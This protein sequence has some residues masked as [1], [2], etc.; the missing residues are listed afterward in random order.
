MRGLNLINLLTTLI[1][2][3]SVNEIKAE[4]A[5]TG[6]LLPNAGD[7]QSSYQNTQDSHTPDKVGS[8]SGFTIDSGIQAFQNELEAKGTGNVTA[9]GSLVGITTEKENGGQF[10]ITAD[11]LDGGVSLNSLTEVQNCEWL[12][13]TSRCGSATAGADSYK[14]ILKILDDNNNVLATTSITRNN[15]A[16]YGV[17]SYTYS[18]TIAHNGTGARKW[19]WQWQG[20]DG[21][22]T[23]ATASV[24]PNLLGASL[25]ATL[26]DI[27]FQ[28]LTEEQSTNIS[29]ANTQ[30][31]ESQTA[32]TEVFKDVK[33]FKP[34]VNIEIAPRIER[35]E[36][37]IEEFKAPAIEMKKL[38][39]MVIE[40]FKQIIVKENLVQEFNTALVEEN[41][42]EE[43][44]F[45]EV[46]NMM[47]EELNVVPEPK[48]KEPKMEENNVVAK[49]S[50][51]EEETI[52][53][54][55]K[56]KGEP[57]VENEPKKEES[58][59]SNSTEPKP[60]TTKENETSS[61][62]KPEESENTEEKSNESSMDEDTETEGEETKKT[63]EEKLDADETGTTKKADVDSG[64][65]KSIASSISAKVE[66]IIKKLE[67]TLMTVDQKVKAV[68]FI[69]LRAMS[70]EAPDM[71]SYKNQSF[72]S[73]TQLPD[74]NVDFFNQLNIEQTQI[75]TGVTL[76]KYTD[77]D[78]LT[79]QRV[80]L[81]RIKTE[82]TRL[83][84]EL[85]QLREQ[86]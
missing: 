12:G 83:Q 7:G 77:N 15:D 29:S 44:F 35:Q 24:G 50:N 74:G 71:S 46:G 84:I 78:P 75:Y 86:L 68:Q 5:T 63:N 42:T 81:D 85:K 36:V 58:N 40:Q 11:S 52:K 41:I 9:N 39:T 38:E 30:I 6:N 64:D 45:E 32:L 61:E 69:T 60:E 62:N 55:P 13:S 3:I 43:Q 19:D 10:N 79:S 54:E 49:K 34:E 51:L 59:A 1:L 48:V 31:E 26:A 33:Q 82:E 56:V 21:N 20:I 28:Q 8:G 65:E 4:E 57:K 66:K 2:I 47:K 72:Y 53:E 27:N 22:N 16:G 17:N 14:T 67:N 18:D 37:K 73:S 25:T 70:D 80:E 76:A 23:S